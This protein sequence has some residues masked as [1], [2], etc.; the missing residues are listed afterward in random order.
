MEI[1]NIPTDTARGIKFVAKEDGK[2]VGR[3]YLYILYNDLHS[4]PFGLL[5][6]VFVEEECRGRGI[7]TALTKAVIAEAKVQRCYKLI[8]QSRY[9]RDKV[10]QLYLSLGFVDHGKNFRMDF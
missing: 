9:G 4:E 8:G 1:T 6:D 10:H 5:E 7:G 2:D 3:A